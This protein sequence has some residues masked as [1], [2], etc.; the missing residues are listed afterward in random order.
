MLNVL[1]RLNSTGTF[2]DYV[3]QTS[4]AH[5]PKDKF[6]TV[7]I[8][9]PTR[10]EQEAIAGA[11]SDADAWIESLEKLIEKKRAIKQGTMQALLTPPDQPGHQRLP[12]FDG[13][14]EV[15][16]L[17]KVLSI[18]HGRSQKDVATQYGCYPILA[19]GGT[20]G[21]TD[22][23]L[24][25][26]PSVLIGRK[27]TIDKPQFMARP[28]WSVDTLFYSEIRE[29]NCAK[30]VFY[31]FCLVEWSRHNEASG[32]PSLNAYTIEAIELPYHNWCLRH[33]RT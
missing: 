18:R 26:G 32:V 28:F 24:H 16:P 17:G 30:F 33:A 29:Q 7:P 22:S 15:A 19:T 1:E 4:I 25:P 11:L 14:W 31:R 21:R 3:T 2:S 20:I 8:P 6:E 23:S 27:G 12:G 9:R 5:L 13:E 10:A